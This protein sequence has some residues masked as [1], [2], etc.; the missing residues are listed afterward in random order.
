MAINLPKLMLVYDRYHKATATRVS[1]VELR[2]TYN[3]KQKYINTGIY[4]YPKQWKN[5]TVINRPDALQLNQQLDKLMINVRQII[6]DMSNNINIEIIPIKLKEM[7]TSL[8]TFIEERAKIREYG[9]AKDTQERY[10]RFIRL[11]K[12]YG[13]IVSFDDLTESNI[14]LYDE[15]LKAKGMK[16]YSKWNNYHRFLNSFIMDAID[17]GYMK[18]N[19][20]KWVK[21]YKGKEDDSCRYLTPEEFK[22]IRNAVL[23]TE[24]L[25]RVRDVF[26]FQT[27]TLL[28]Y[29]DLKNL[30]ISRIME[31][32]GMKV[33][34]GKREKTGGQYTIPLVDDAL[35]IL[36]KY[37][38]K[39]PIISNVKYNQYLKVVAQAAGIDKPV[40]T[41]WARHT[42]ATLLF[43]KGVDM[44]I[45]SKICGHATTA[46]TAKVY[47]KM[48]DET[49]VDA[50][51]N[52]NKH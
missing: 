16:D 21:I 42:G 12:E 13:K 32:N 19:P 25:N 11:F 10:K 44:R 34:T 22:S 9:K 52:A 23:K 4:L 46:I 28:S 43:N 37:N 17:A 14:I 3:Y 27:L 2:V 30:D 41:H 49:V 38:N 20:Y 31:I 33:Y 35:E 29:S 15:F 6:T 5:N 7:N 1:I 24:S 18:R 39:L 51:K 8:Y 45:I 47:A 50:I 48:L 26:V 40:S 36:Q